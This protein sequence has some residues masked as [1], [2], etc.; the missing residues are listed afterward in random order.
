[1]A[2]WNVGDSVNV[3]DMAVSIVIVFY[4]DVIDGLR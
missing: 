3:S 1:M 2:T 4:V